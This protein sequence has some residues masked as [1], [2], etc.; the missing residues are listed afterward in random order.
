MKHQ[1][2]VDLLEFKASFL[3]FHWLEHFEHDGI[4]SRWFCRCQSGM[5]RAAKTSQQ[6]D[7]R[8]GILFEALIWRSKSP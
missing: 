5:R 8:R 7:R 2:G 1:F 4:N 3:A 6:P